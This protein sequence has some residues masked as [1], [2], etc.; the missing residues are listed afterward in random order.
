MASG[1]QRSKRKKSTTKSRKKEQLQMHIYEFCCA[2]QNLMPW[3]RAI[4][5]TNTVLQCSTVCRFVLM[6]IFNGSAAGLDR[7][8]LNTKR[9]ERWTFRCA[10]FSMCNFSMQLTNKIYLK[11]Y[12]GYTL[13][14][15]RAWNVCVCFRWY[16]FLF[17]FSLSHNERRDEN[18]VFIAMSVPFFHNAI[19]IY[20]NS[21]HLNM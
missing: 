12:C 6:A 9:W 4:K 3:K 11:I 19:K 15:L 14:E 16:Y 8:S 5:W 7:Y 13:N 1:R 18:I 21:L 10:Q 20:T 17:A 2:H